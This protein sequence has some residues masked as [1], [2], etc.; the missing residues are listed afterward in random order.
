MMKR[1]ALLLLCVVL[2][3]GCWRPYDTPVF[4]DIGNSETA[5]LIQKEGDQKQA[6]LKSEEMLAKNMVQSKRVEITYRWI[7]TGRGLGVGKYIPNEQLVIVDRKPETREWTADRTGSDAKDQAIWAESSDSVGFSTG[8]SITARIQDQN[9][10]TKFLYNYP[11]QEGRTVDDPGWSKDPYI[12]KESDLADIMDQEVRTKIQEVFAEKAAEYNMDEL[13][14]KKN[15]IIGSIR[16]E[17]IPFFDE[18]GVTITA[19]GLF[20][21]FTYENPKIQEAI[22]KVFEQQQDEEIAKAEQKAAEQRKEAL[23]LKGEGQAQE[24]IEIA[25]GKAE[26]IKLEAEAE[27]EA[28]QAVADAKAYELEKLT[29]NP[30]AY[31]TLKQIEVDMERISV[32]DGQYPSYYIGSDL[33]ISGEN[34]NMFLPSPRIIPTESTPVKQVSAPVSAE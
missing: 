8:I 6:T 28:I 31:I 16:E 18:R 15:E 23:K 30:E 34:L 14:E 27:A 22:D 13:R 29:S 21:G 4:V 20:G 17:V 7:K 19:I 2:C 10:A 12:V 32:W 5:F 1:L 33:G 25:K 24:T 9:D 11:A 26:S 3:T